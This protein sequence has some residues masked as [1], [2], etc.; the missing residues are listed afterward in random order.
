LLD[1]KASCEGHWLN[2]DL[3]RQ[4]LT[5][6]GFVFQ[7]HDQFLFLTAFL[8]KMTRER[9]NVIPV[10]THDKKTIGRAGVSPGG[11]PRMP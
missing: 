6:T 9:Q 4:R 3:R 5:Q 10:A 8:K 11:C 7:F 1:G 2:T